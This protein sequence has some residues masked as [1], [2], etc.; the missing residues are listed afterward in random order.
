MEKVSKR[1]SAIQ[2]VKESVSLLSQLL[3]GFSRESSSQSNQELV[4]VS[5]ETQ[6][7]GDRLQARGP[8]RSSFAPP[9]HGSA[10]LCR[11]CTSAVRR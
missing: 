6:H 10:S 4:K 2:E 9:T 8:L 5:A 7:I 3:Q 1:E 11:I